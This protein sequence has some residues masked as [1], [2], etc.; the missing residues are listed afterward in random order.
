MVTTFVSEMFFDRG[1]VLP[2]ENNI[3]KQFQS[4]SIQIAP[5]ILAANFADLGRECE[6]VTEA[7][8]DWIH[9]DV[10]DGR[11]V[12]AMSFGTQMVSTLRRHISGVMDLHLMIENTDLVID[13][14]IPCGADRLTVHVEAC[15]HLHRV[16]T[17]IRAAGIKAGVAL[18][19][20]TPIS[21]V[22]EVLDCIDQ[23][24]IMTVNPGY[25]GQEFISAQLD[26]IRAMRCVV[27]NRPI[28]IEVDGGVTKHNAETIVK[29]GADVLVAGSAIF[30]TE[31]NQHADHY[32]ENIDGIRK[33]VDC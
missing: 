13:E 18:N 4:R 31:P 12:P 19:P 21:T 9:V 17:E 28:K 3:M 15:N 23:V 10:M 25:G 14:Y 30:G 5:S 11:F 29:A 33:I 26:K 2:K 8:C 7:G 24:C 22:S 1:N 27:G 20:S 16:L 6:A 32:R